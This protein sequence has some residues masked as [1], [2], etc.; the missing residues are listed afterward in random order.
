MALLARDGRRERD[1]W[2][3][4]PVLLFLGLLVFASLVSHI[5]I[6]VRHVLILYPFLVLGA[7]HAIA[8]AWRCLR[9]V[10]DRD[11]AG[12]G[13]AAAGG[14][15]AWQLGTLWTANPDYLP[16]FN[17]AVPHPER[18]LVDS[19][20]AWG[21]DLRRLERR[22]RE[23]DVPSF[24]FA[25]LGTADLSRETFPPLTRLPPN[26]RAT[27]W[28]AITELARVHSLRGYAWLDAYVPIERIGKSICLYYISGSLD[29][30]RPQ[31]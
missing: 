18:V 29:V 17:E 9:R 16:Y 26:Q 30:D 19:D 28:I 24:S 12:V 23:L 14:L 1:L 31:P 7:S 22:L 15:V 5:N 20:L 10:S 8:H 21:H 2:R 11:W 27:G 6:G 25:Y 13:C 4:A 3:L